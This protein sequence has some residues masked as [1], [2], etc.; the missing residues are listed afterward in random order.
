MTRRTSVCVVLAATC[1][2]AAL[3][4]WFV[5]F[6]TGEGK[7]L[8]ARVLRD[9]RSLPPILTVRPS[10]DTV[11]LLRPGTYVAIAVLLPVI[12]VL[13][14][15]RYEAVAALLVLAGSNATT[16]MLKMLLDTSQGPL[17]RLNTPWPSG[18]TTAV[19]ALGA[20]VVIVIPWRWRPLA[21]AVGSVA[22]VAMSFAVL[23][24]A[25]HRL[26]DVIGALL[27][28]GGWVALAA[29]MNP[30]ASGDTGLRP[31]PLLAPLGCAVA[32]SALATLLHASWRR[33]VL[34][35]RLSADMMLPLA[36]AFIALL[37]AGVSI[38]TAFAFGRD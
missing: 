33:G 25:T 38:G 30:A 36:M 26:S 9:F 10:L 27:I 12:A 21:A 1:A 20:A 8:D 14:G 18:H 6:N 7:A 13:R 22:A 31:F 35:D 37:A 24:L 29:A 3:A 4:T 23:V 11:A 5:A 19:M 15:R 16:Q 28:T 17:P 32:V 34:F 2:G